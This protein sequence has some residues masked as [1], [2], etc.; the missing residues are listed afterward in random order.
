LEK[1]EDTYAL[2]LTPGSIPEVVHLS[3]YDSGVRDIKFLLYAGSRPYTVQTGSTVTIRGGKPDGTIYEYT[4]AVTGNAVTVTP[5]V[6][7]TAVRGFHDAEIRIYNGSDMIG[8][9]NIRIMV[10]Q[11]PFPES[12]RASATEIPLV[13]GAHKAAFD[14]EEYKNSALNSQNAASESATQAANSATAAGNS[15]KAAATSET[16]AKT[17]E[18]NAASS[19]SA[20]AASEK[21]AMSATPDGYASLAST[22]NALGLYVDAEGYTCQAINEEAKD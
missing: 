18:T 8:S 1:I 7:M 13:E 2:D 14:A 6:Q 4:C 20:A 9:A 16:A 19:A 17:S 22:F 5:T 3:Q 11:S 12:F 21:N 15:A 10:E